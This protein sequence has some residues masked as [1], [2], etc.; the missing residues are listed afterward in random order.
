MRGWR[1]SASRPAPDAAPDR[2]PVDSDSRAPV[3]ADSLGPGQPLDAQTRQRMESAF[4]ESFEHIQIHNGPEAGEVNRRLSAQ[5]LTV[6][7]H[8]AFAPGNYRP[9]T[10]V[11]D[12]MLA[13]ELAHSLQQGGGPARASDGAPPVEPV[14]SA[15]ETDADHAAIGAMRT[16]S[17]AAGAAPAASFP[18]SRP[19]L[20]SALR[21]QRC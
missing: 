5:A 11:G 6:G 2:G 15:L 7:E 3:F 13:H 17:H 8:V 9:G 21:V 14:G 4:G 18:A 16:L 1:E 20:R 10:P 19:A 12:A